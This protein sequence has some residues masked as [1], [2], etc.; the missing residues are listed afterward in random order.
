M[1]STQ[2]VR[3]LELAALGA[4]DRGATLDH[5]DNLALR[6]RVVEEMA[7]LS[8]SEVDDLR[9]AAHSLMHAAIR[10]LSR[11]RVEQ[12]ARGKGELSGAPDWLQ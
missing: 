4:N 3:L 5:D 1:I 11:R 12:G 7:P 9:N 8:Y 6:Q 10:E 2:Y